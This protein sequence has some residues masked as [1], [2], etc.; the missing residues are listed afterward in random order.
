MKKAL[1]TGATGQVGLYFTRLLVNKGYEFTTTTANGIP[2]SAIVAKAEI[3][4]EM[5][6]IFFSGTFGREL[7]SLA[8]TDEVLNCLGRSLSDS[9][10]ESSDQFV[11]GLEKF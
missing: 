5:E 3:M 1:V 9:I 6:N 8:A 4:D 11:C 10:I 2:I 7:L